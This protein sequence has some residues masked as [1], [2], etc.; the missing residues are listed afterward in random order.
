MAGFSADY[1]K[2]RAISGPIAG[3]YVDTA[4]NWQNGNPVLGVGQLGIESDTG[5]VKWGDAVT[6]WNDL[7]YR[8]EID[9][10]VVS[11]VTDIP[12]ADAITNIVSLTQAE[13][14]AIESPAATTLYVITD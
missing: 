8:F 2:K 5:R 12:G 6:H 11:D 13:Y 9:N 4:E 7:E 14:D 1:I 10:A 3:Q